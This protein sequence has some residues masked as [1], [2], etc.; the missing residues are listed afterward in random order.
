MHRVYTHTGWYISDLDSKLLYAY[1]LCLLASRVG[2]TYVGLFSL[3]KTR[4][5]GSWKVSY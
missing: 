2:K 1:K 3:N 5:P 4:Q